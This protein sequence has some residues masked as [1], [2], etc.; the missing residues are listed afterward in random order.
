MTWLHHPEMP[1]QQR[2]ATVTK[3]KKSNKHSVIYIN[4]GVPR[5]GLPPFAPFDA[6][7]DWSA[8]GQRWHKWV[9]R[10]NNLLINLQKFD[11][12]VRRG[13]LLAYVREETNDIF[14]SLF[15]TRDKY[16]TA[17]TKLNKYLEPSNNTDMAIFEFRE[18]K[19]KWGEPINEIYRLLK[20]EAALCEFS[21]EDPEI[22]TQVIHKTTDSRLRRKALRETMTLRELFTYVNTLEKTDIESKKIVGIK[23]YLTSSNHTYIPYANKIHDG[24]QTLEVEL[25]H[26]IKV[27]KIKIHHYL[28]SA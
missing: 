16:E 10:F 25:E 18:M 2:K 14:D 19:Q 6:H 13:L 26:N 21:N 24:I 27:Y 28:R 5:S 15:E 8:V 20:E 11:L 17:M 1:K 7:K 23:E 4:M 9:K 12:K 3:L 22:K